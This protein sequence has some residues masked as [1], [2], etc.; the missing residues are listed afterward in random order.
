MC[1]LLGFAIESYRVIASI[2]MYATYQVLLIV[3]KYRAIGR[4]INRHKQ[5]FQKGVRIAIKSNE[6]SSKLAI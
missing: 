5:K 3:L 4:L 1:D 2:L 6:T